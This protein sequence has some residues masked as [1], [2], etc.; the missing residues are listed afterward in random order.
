[1]TFHAAPSLRR[2]SYALLPGLALVLVLASPARVSNAHPAASGLPADEGSASLA[3]LD[4]AVERGEMT[5]A[6]AGRQ[7][8]LFLFERGHMD[9]AYSLDGNRPARCATLVIEDLRQNLDRLD[10]GG[11]ALYDRYVTGGGL[12][13]TSSGGPAPN[14]L[15]VHETTHFWIEYNTTGPNVVPL[16]DVA[17][18]NGVPDFVEATAA[19]METSWQTA[20]ITLGY[21]AAPG[22]STT[23]Y[24]GK[25]LVQFQAQGA[26]GFTTV[27]SGARTRIVLHNNYIGFPPNDDPDGPVLGAL[28]VTG[29]HEYK[30]AIQRT[31]SLWSEGGWL[32]LDATWMEDIVYDNVNDY[33]NYISGPASPFT[34]PQTPLDVDAFGSTGSYE[35]CNWQLYQTEKFGL[36]HMRDFWI[37][38]QSNPGEPVMFTYDMTI[39]LSGS[40]LPDAWGEYVTW[41]FASGTRAGTNAYGYGE[42]PG[43]PTVPVTSSH[44]TLPVATTPGSVAHLAANIR[45]ITNG[46]GALSGQPEFTF[47]GAVAVAWR[48]SVI[49]K[50]LAGN[51]TRVPM[52]LVSGAGTLLVPGADY[53]NLQY[54]ALV[55]G[56]P[57]TSGAAAAY[58]FSARA[59][60]PIFVEHQRVWDTIETVSPY[61]IRTRV[62][63]GTGTPNPSSVTLSYRVDGGSLSALSMTPTGNPDEYEASIPA[64]P[65]GSHVEYRIEAQ[66]LLGDPASAPGIA[67]AFHA[68]DVVTVFEPFE[69]AGGWTVGA[70]GDAA[71]SGL[72]TRVVPLGTVAQPGED[73]TI[74]P[75]TTCFVTANGTPGGAA[76]EADV[77]GGRTTLVSPVF[78]LSAGAPYSSVGVR[79]RRW[80]SNGLGA[81]VDDTWRVEV[82]N[83]GGTVWQTLESTTTGAETWQLV[84]DD[85]LARFGT[86]NQLRFR[87]LAEDLGAG[88][89]IEAG[90]DDFEL[91]AVPQSAVAVPGGPRG[92]TFALGAAWPSPSRASVSFALDLSQPSPVRARVL[93]A[94][95]RLVR[96]VTDET[97]RPAGSSRLV[98]DGRDEAGRSAGS[99]RYFLEVRAG[100]A[101]ATRTFVRVR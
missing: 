53:A 49:L 65:V 101:R 62:V 95:G 76:G 55:I 87:F 97:L 35:D 67:G 57:T 100:D 88:S 45:L 15:L 17:P 5:Y 44:A 83:D 73:F 93:D 84:T 90:I 81:A 99:G 29:A 34:E 40:T 36:A 59:V 19:T 66:S 18:A 39:Q 98:W 61:L 10:E 42:A 43:Y 74:P 3:A 63:P 82:S 22:S 14:V 30:H 8:L 9:A 12:S 70:P 2:A 89:L 94:S 27:T 20:V 78:D 54:A 33:Y 16:L 1:M 71:T 37:R 56:N 64:Q 46:D 38:R 6:A 41:N 23:L 91:I 11:R 92:G 60:A 58:T 52:P 4:A 28:R 47:N 48:V 77:D 69:S 31:Y 86:V 96:V 25:Y 32:E 80:Y 85:L 24:N 7:K 68:Y 21:N 75:G 26:Y 13:T 51:V 79:F 50:D 72:W